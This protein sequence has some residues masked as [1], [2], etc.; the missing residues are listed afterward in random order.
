MLLKGAV[1]SNDV[2]V[3]L[4]FLLKT[5]TCQN[6]VFF[7]SMAVSK[8]GLYTIIDPSISTQRTYFELKTSCV[9]KP[10]WKTGRVKGGSRWIVSLF[11]IHGSTEEQTN[12][13]SVPVETVGGAVESGWCQQE[14]T[15][16]LVP[17]NNNNNDDSHFNK[18]LKC[19]VFLQPSPRLISICNA[20]P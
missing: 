17:D 9:I 10:A 5:F 18:L 16:L 6:F 11:K 4:F 14:R 12:S 15:C 20:S 8:D 13:T 1:I 7:Y 3:P 19:G 2:L